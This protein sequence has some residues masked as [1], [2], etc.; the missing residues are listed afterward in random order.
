MET[1]L[2]KKL[3][4]EAPG[5]AG[6]M[7]ASKMAQEGAIYKL[8]DQPQGLRTPVCLLPEYSAGDNIPVYLILSKQFKWMPLL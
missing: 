3:T 2:S 1:L 8:V 5:Q 4:A 7:G 6:A